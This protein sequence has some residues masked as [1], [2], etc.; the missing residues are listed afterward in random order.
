MLE[1]C[2][3]LDPLTL[4]SSRDFV[5]SNYHIWS[6]NQEKQKKEM[7]RQLSISLLRPNSL[8]RLCMSSVVTTELQK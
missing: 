3:V 4:V 6:Q 8:L 1:N 5:R 7:L 2:A